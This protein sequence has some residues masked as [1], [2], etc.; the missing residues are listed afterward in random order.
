ME[1]Y[2]IVENYSNIYEIKKYDTGSDTYVVISELQTYESALAAIKI[3]KE[4][5]WD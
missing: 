3:L 4:E 2:I 1:P 5:D